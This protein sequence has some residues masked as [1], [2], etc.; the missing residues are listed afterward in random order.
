[1]DWL[2]DNVIGGLPNPEQILPVSRAMVQELGIYQD[3][4]LKKKEGAG[5]ED[6][7]SL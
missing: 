3:G 1:M 6:S 2:C 7:V 5:N 4:G